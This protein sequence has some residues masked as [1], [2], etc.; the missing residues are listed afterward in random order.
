MKQYPILNLLLLSLALYSC[1]SSPKNKK[2]ERTKRQFT[3]QDAVVNYLVLKGF[4]N[5][6]F[7]FQTLG[8]NVTCERYD[9]YRKEIYFSALNDA[10]FL[11]L[12]DNICTDTSVVDYGVIAP[13]SGKVYL[14]KL[15]MKD[16]TKML[17]RFPSSYLKI[18]STRIITQKFGK[19]T[20]QMS[21]YD[22]RN[23]LSAENLYNGP[24]LAV[25]DTTPNGTLK[26]MAN[27]AA[28]IARPGEPTLNQL[29]SQL[30]DS[31]QSLERKAQRLLD[32]VSFEITY[33]NHGKHEIFMKPNETLLAKASD[34]SGKVVLYSSLLSQLEIPHI[35]VYTPGHICVG[36]KGDFDKSNGM[37]FDHETGRYFL[38][39]T[40]VGGF[41]IGQTRLVNPIRE[42]VFEYL[43]FPGKYSKIFDLVMMDSLEFAVME[44]E[45]D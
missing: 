31:T 40:T 4:S 24:A 12:V 33:K 2:T 14:D 36:V 6:D 3:L 11:E 15:V 18:D 38:A 28:P 10:H 43:Q 27:H 21:L 22:L 8:E 25:T 42:E 17:F 45:V 5:A 39:E 20:Y 32:F 19:I 34:C 7:A 13:K 16:T 9:P 37:Y 35:L 1:S 41:Q 23:F 44:I 26:V 29:I 30:T